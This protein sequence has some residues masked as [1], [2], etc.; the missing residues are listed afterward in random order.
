MDAREQLR[1]AF[2][3]FTAMGMEAFAA[4]AERELLA[5][6]ECV[7]KRTVETRDDLTA[8]ETQIARLAREL[9]AL[10]GPEAE[11]SELIET[12]APV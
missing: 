5:T 4:R 9:V 6:G 8:Q 1:T 10:R 7:R 11:L 2:E 3:M 12:T